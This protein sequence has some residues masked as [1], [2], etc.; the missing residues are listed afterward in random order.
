MLL[1]CVV[2]YSQNSSAGRLSLESMCKLI[3]YFKVLY[4][5]SEAIPACTDVLRTAN[6]IL[7]WPDRFLKC[8][9][10][11]IM[12]PLFFSDNYTFLKLLLFI[13]QRIAI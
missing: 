8:C 10:N 13:L 6:T 4:P 7:D 9:I 1:Y 12:C 5:K 3:G 2:V 11:E